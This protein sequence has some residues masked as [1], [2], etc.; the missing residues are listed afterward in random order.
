MSNNPVVNRPVLLAFVV[1]FLAVAGV[2][3]SAALLLPEDDPDASM[4]SGLTGTP[5][6][7]PTPAFPTI[8]PLPAAPDPGRNVPEVTLIDTQ[9]GGMIPLWERGYRVHEVVFN[10]ETLYYVR[11]PVVTRV[12]DAEII[13]LEL[14][15]HS[16]H[17]LADGFNIAVSV[18]GDIAYSTSSGG[19]ILDRFRRPGPDPGGSGRFQW[20][21]DGRW[22]T[23]S[24]DYQGDGAPMKQYIMDFSFRAVTVREFAETLPCNCDGNPGVHWAPDSTRFEYTRIV[25]TPGQGERTSEIYEPWGL[26]KFASPEFLRW[27][28]SSR[29]VAGGREENDGQYTI[30]DFVSGSSVNVG[31]VAALSPDSSLLASVAGPLGQ[32]IAVQETNGSTLLTGL[33]GL[34]SEFSQD[35]KYLLASSSTGGCPGLNVYR[36]SDG[37]VHYCRTLAAG[38][39]SPDSTKLAVVAVDPPNHLAPQTA[40]VWLIDLTTGSERRLATDLRGGL[41]CA[42]WSADSRYV[43]ITFCPGV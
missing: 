9:Y 33:D 1:F 26:T 15:S 6:T 10:N 23:S 40:E 24:E 43:A 32:T 16:R 2:V 42:K 14:Q 28:S 5:V 34:P 38:A 22:L 4:P 39:F 37:Q 8:P 31:H 13:A 35:N 21:P 41:G 18:N 19:A 29:Y 25:G 12:E 20:S 7:N 11:F 36:V 17:K 30:R 27:V 3:A